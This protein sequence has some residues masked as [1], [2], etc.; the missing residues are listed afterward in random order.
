M[1]EAYAI[2]SLSLLIHSEFYMNPFSSNTRAE[3]KDHAKDTFEHLGGWGALSVATAFA[4]ICVVVAE[5]VHVQPE[6]AAELTKP[7]DVRRAGTSNQPT[8]LDIRFF[9]EPVKS[10]RAI[11]K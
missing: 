11:T 7:L 8:N 10:D 6:I 1:L 3:F 2:G 9:P 5:S 4:A